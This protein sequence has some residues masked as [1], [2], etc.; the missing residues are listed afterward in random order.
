MWAAPTISA[1]RACARFMKALSGRRQ[2]ARS[3]LF[4]RPVASASMTEARPTGAQPEARS[5]ENLGARHRTGA[6]GQD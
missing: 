3:P 2:E 4:F 1:R 6:A 5:V